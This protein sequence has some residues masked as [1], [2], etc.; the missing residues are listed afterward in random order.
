M[1]IIEITTGAV[2]AEIMTNHGMTLD[3]AIN[4]V[5]DMRWDEDDMYQAVVIN[6]STYDYD[7]LDI[8]NAQCMPAV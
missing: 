8:C 6:G 7:N 2:I 1:K 4:I 3:E 5:G